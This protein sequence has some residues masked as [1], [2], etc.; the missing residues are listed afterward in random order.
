MFE[1][2]PALREARERRGLGLNQV[3]TATAIRSRY[4]RALEDEEFDVLP[5]PT[6]AKGFLRAYAEYLGLD[7]DLFIDEFNSRHHDPRRELEQPIYSRPRSQPQ[8]R[9][10]QR[11]ET[12]LVMIALA[13]IVAVASLIFIASTL[14]NPTAPAV[15][16]PATNHTPATGGQTGTTPPG[17][18]Q[19]QPSTTKKK[20]AT[21]KQFHVVFT[22]SSP[23]SCWVSVHAGSPNG[24]AA[25]TTHGT[26]LLGYKIDSAVAPSIEVV[27]K[28]PLFVSQIGAP[29]SLTVTIDGHTYPLPAGV[30]PATVLRLDKTGIHPA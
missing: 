23:N 4:L 8:Q 3:E 21:H 18:G 25:Q 5:G 6:Y 19:T 9:R 12:N 15:P 22:V 17:T 27:S 26:S 20:P 7:G 28:Q 14:H 16:P 30:T 13:A 29:A 24:K 11:R 10:R 1:I 2:G